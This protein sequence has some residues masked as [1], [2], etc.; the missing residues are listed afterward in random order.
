MLQFSFKI[1]PIGVSI[2]TAAD[3]FIRLELKVTEKFYLKITED[4]QTTPIEVTT[5]SSDFADEEHFLFT[6]ADGEDETKEQIFQRKKQSWKKPTEWVA[7]QEP[8]S[9]ERSIQ[10]FKKIDG[11]TTSHSINGIKANARIRTEQ[12]A[13]LVLKNLKLKLLDEPHD[14][15]LLT[16][17]RRF[18]LYKANEDRIIFVDGSPFGKNYGETSSI[19]YYQN[20]ILKRLVSEVL[21]SLHGESEKH[22]GITKTIIAYREKYYCPIMAQLIREWVKSYEQCLK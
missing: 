18:E 5:I 12:D 17:D 10:E 9:M 13:D 1:A 3:F 22:P 8:Y 19:R 7:I 6:H 20:F 21:W 15:V 16:T 4:V 2:N 11:N 14:D